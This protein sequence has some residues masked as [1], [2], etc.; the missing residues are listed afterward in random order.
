MTE[1]DLFSIV[2]DYT[3]RKIGIMSFDSFHGPEFL[4]WYS[5]NNWHCVSFALALKKFLNKRGHNPDLIGVYV[6]RDTYNGDD[7][8]YDPDSFNWNKNESFYHVYLQMNGIA[9]DARGVVSPSR[10]IIDAEH[11]SVSFIPMTD[12]R[13]V[14]AKKDSKWKQSRE[15]AIYQWFEIMALKKSFA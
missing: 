12:T 3:D 15:D 9:F 2:T 13:L 11:L 10:E 14:S 1:N 8:N 7:E 4:F 5:H 6:D